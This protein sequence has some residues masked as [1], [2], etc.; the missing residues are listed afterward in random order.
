MRFIILFL[1]VFSAYACTGV[2]GSA[3]ADESTVKTYIYEGI[4][5]SYPE[6]GKALELP[7]DGE[8]IHFAVQV[9]FWTENS[10][11]WVVQM[12]AGIE[13]RGNEVWIPGLRDSASADK[14]KAIVIAHQPPE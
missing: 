6:T 7:F 13:I 14:W 9:H 10:Q 4:G 12:A 8:E 2:T 1:A 5:T 11:S 3:D